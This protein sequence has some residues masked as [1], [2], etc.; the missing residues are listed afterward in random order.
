MAVSLNR[1]GEDTQLS[2][3]LLFNATTA[4]RDAIA[5]IFNK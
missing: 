3:E 2:I 5:A 1:E 4:N